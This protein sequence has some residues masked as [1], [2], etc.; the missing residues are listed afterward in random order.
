MIAIDLETT[1]R[2]VVN[3]LEL[4]LAISHEIHHGSIC[5]ELIHILIVRLLVDMSD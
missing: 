4:I 2:V 5:L 1:T 3:E